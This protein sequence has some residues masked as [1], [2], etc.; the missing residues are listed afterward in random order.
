MLVRPSTPQ[1][2]YAARRAKVLGS[3]KPNEAMILF[4][5]PEQVRSRDT[6]YGYRPSSD[7]FYL[8]GFSEPGA[9]LVLRPGEGG[10]Q[11]TLFVRPRDP[12]RETWDGKRLGVEAAPAALGVDQAFPIEELEGRWKALLSGVERLHHAYGHEPELDAK[13][14]AW[15]GRLGTRD[16][17]PPSELVH[18]GVILHEMR[19]HKE[20]IEL[21]WMRHAAAITTEAYAQ[22]LQA[23][24]P[25]GHEHEVQAALEG[26]Y[27]RL[28][29]DGPAYGSIVAGGKDA[30]ILH[31][32]ENGKA[33]EAG[34][35][36][37]I[38]SGAEAGWYAC[39]VSRTYPV[40]GRFSPAQRAVYAWVLK[41]QK[42]A[43]EAVRPGQHVKAY[44]EVAV[45][46]LTEGL[47]DLGVLQ[48][49][50]DE[51]VASEAYKPYYMHGTG[52]YLGLDTHDVG[53]YR[54]HNGGPWRAMEPGMVVTVEPG[55]YFNPELPGI[56]PELAG[57]GVRIEDDLV[58]TAEGHENL[59]SAIPKEIAEVEAALAGHLATA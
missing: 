21:A 56:P 8:T 11:A 26:C 17:L 55:L 19:L 37:L 58:V 1:Q 14:L 2:V 13:V 52:H 9:C 49:P 5:N 42:A 33:L 22:A 23:I 48:G 43:C 18:A 31:Y 46:I 51:L 35:L 30:C 29:G 47:V 24:R 50:V 6:C 25:G 57:I 39:D 53:R 12:E 45:R 38:D 32:T 15:L 28:G 59:T 27:R 4:A 54:T 7:L 36:L 34:S 10:P 40:G 3:L 20:P 44:H 16:L 41:A